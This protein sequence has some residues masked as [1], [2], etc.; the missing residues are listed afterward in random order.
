M[1]V[2]DVYNLLNEIAPFCL[3]ESWDNCGLL[4]GCADKEVS[5]IMPVLDV[6]TDVVLEA[7]EN[8]VD[9]IVS[10]HPI[11]FNGLKAIDS[12][13]VVYRLIENNIAVI[14]AHTN[15]DMAKN[16]VT[17]VLAGLLGLNNQRIVNKLGVNNDIE[18]GE[19][20]IG[21]LNA[22]IT[23]KMLAELVKNKLGCEA[24]KLVEG[25][26]SIKTVVV[27]NGS[28]NNML[29]YA[30]KLNADAVVAGETKHNVMIDAKNCGITLIDAGHFETENIIIASLE[31][32]FNDRLNGVKVV[33]S[34]TNNCPYTFI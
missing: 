20:I 30:V 13:S 16:G 26:N 34:K 11:I 28:E 15:L 12:D 27:A 3:A 14:S 22:G 1:L 29:S 25:K 19:G 32:I 33:H 4:I 6:T 9:L 10:H 8:N 2:S 24:V 5:N 31:E 7:V 17:K 21:E 23:P 18:F